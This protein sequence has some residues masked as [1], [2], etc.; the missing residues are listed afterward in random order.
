M[1]AN[2]IAVEADAPKCRLGLGGRA[3]S[4]VTAGLVA[5]VGI[6]MM[7]QASVVG[8]TTRYPSVK[9]KLL[10]IAEMPA[11]WRVD[12][13]SS[14]GG[15][16][17]TKCLAGLN[18]ANKTPGQAGV[19][20]EDGAGVPFVGEVIGSGQKV[21]RAFSEISS[22]LA[23]CKTLQ[24]KE[25]GATYRGTIGALSFPTIG[26]KSSAFLISFTIKGVTAGIDLVVFATG[27]YVGALTYGNIGTPEITQVEA[28]AH[29]ALAKLVGSTLPSVPTTT[30]TPPTSVS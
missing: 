19:S 17:G 3:Q 14:N 4:V 23:E 10:T 2:W 8:A 18:K 22:R 16:G 20:F 1:T 11:G 21:T 13:S 6:A 25:G 27:S 5:F 29:L 9:G 12:N 26:S 30:T 28:F 24:L 7:M 15:L